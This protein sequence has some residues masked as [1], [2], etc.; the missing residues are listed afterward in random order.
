MIVLQ[1]FTKDNKQ[2]VIV[3]TDLVAAKRIAELRPFFDSFGLFTEVNESSARLLYRDM[4]LYT[5]SIYDCFHSGCS[6]HALGVLDYLV[7]KGVKKPM[8]YSQEGEALI[9][10]WIGVV[11]TLVDDSII[12]KTSK[13]EK[14]FDIPDVVFTKDVLAM[15]GAK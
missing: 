2:R 9:M 13:E 12:V 6:A 8:A 15:M 14:R 4:D 5:H 1:Y 7:E 3:S 11:V 10:K